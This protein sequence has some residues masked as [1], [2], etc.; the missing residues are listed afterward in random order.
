MDWRIIH[1]NVEEIADSE[2]IIHL[3]GCT[4]DKKSVYC[5]VYGFRPHCYLELPIEYKW[6]RTSCEILYQFICHKLKECPPESYKLEIR[7]TTLYALKR[8]YMRINFYTKSSYMHLNNLT[9]YP[10][11]IDGLNDF[12]KHSFKLHEQNINL[13]I[14]FCVDRQIYPSGWINVSK[15]TKLDHGY[16]DYNIAVDTSRVKPSTKYTN[17][18]QID[19]LICVFDIELHS[20]NRKSSSP[21]ASIPGNV[22]TMISLIF[23][24]LSQKI[25]E[26]DAHTVSLYHCKAKMGIVY[27]CQGDEKRLLRQFVKVLRNGKPDIITGYNINGFDWNAILTR[28]KIHKML[29]DIE[30]WTML[31][32]K[33]NMGKLPEG[34][35]IKDIAWGS[36]A[37][38]KQEKKYVSLNGVLNYDL[39]TEIS[40]NHKL[41]TYNLAYV[42]NHFLKDDT[43]DDMPFQQM[44]MIYDMV[45]SVMKPHIDGIELDYNTC[46]K[47]IKSCVSKE[48]LMN[49]PDGE[50]GFLVNHP[51]DF[52]NDLD[53]NTNGTYKDAIKLCM[54]YW[55]KMVDYCIQDTLLIPKLMVK[56]NSLISLWENS[57]ICKVPASFIYDRGQQV[58]VTA[59]LVDKFYKKGHVFDYRK[60]EVLPKGDDESESE[61]KKKYQGANLLQMTTGLHRRVV[62]LD[63]TSLYPSIMKQFNMCYT[64]FRTNDDPRV[65][66]ED[67]Y[68]AEWEE[69]RGCVH[70]TVGSKNKNV[71]CGK[72]RYRFLKPTSDPETHGT[73]PE[74]IDELLEYRNRVK[75]EMKVPEK[76]YK[77]LVVLEN[78]TP[79]Q[80]TIMNSNKSLASI[81]D[82]RQLAIKVMNNS[83][84]GYTGIDQKK[85]I[86]PCEAIA[87]SV[88]HFSRRYLKEARDLVLQKWPNSEVIYGDSVSRDTPLLLMKDGLIEIR[89]IESLCTEWKEYRGF[90]MGIPGLSDKQQ[91]STDYKV[92]TDKGWAEIKRV[93]RHHTNKQ[94]YRVN[95]RYGCVDVTEDHSLLD[96]ECRQIKPCELIIGSTELL[97]SYNDYTNDRTNYYN[98]SK[99][100][101]ASLYNGHHV[102]HR[103]GV[104]DLVHD[105]K[106]PNTV[107]SIVELGNCKDYV[108]DL[109][110]SIGRF[111]A[112]VGELIVK[113]T[114]SL[115]V[116]LKNATIE[117]TFAFAREAS[118]YLAEMLPKYIQMKFENVYDPCFLITAKKY[119]YCIVNEKGEIIKEDSKGS[120]KAR[121][122]NCDVAREIYT[123]VNNCIKSIKPVHETIDALN[124]AILDMFRLKYSVKKYVIYT[125]LTKD[126]KEY[127]NIASHIRFAE[128]LQESGNDIK[129]NTRLEF[130]FVKNSDKNAKSGE[131][132]EDFRNFLNNGL[133]LDYA[134]YI[135]HKIEK[136]ITK[137]LNIAYPAIEKPFAKPLEGFKTAMDCYLKPKWVVEIKKLPMQ[138]K[139]LYIIR[140]SRNR[141]LREAA[142]IFYSEWMLETL[143]KKH[144]LP[145]RYHY[146]KRPTSNKTVVLQNDKVLSNIAKYHA[147][148]GQVV[149]QINNLKRNVLR[150]YVARKKK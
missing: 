138:Q 97:H 90:K 115:F 116:K 78:R 71:L 144:G 18:D 119:E 100:Y 30:N 55:K 13:E 14:K 131:R 69:H 32:K 125:C 16:C 12:P 68:I 58:K 2:T 108:Y 101:A 111:H 81:L 70:D 15:I 127:K 4:I 104:Y 27:D 80:E 82:S 98:L 76:I 149:E 95:S 31:P 150:K 110:T 107:L 9:K 87:A 20:I 134:Y 36:S 51:K 23:G 120:M 143:F 37:R 50:G 1:W 132:M 11:K 96:M 43:K 128:R 7:K 57:N 48:E 5:K 133:K 33:F 75:G 85:G 114:D 109:E 122:D 84:Y 22:I 40:F 67:C 72:H 91:G 59:S 130:V 28:M 62:I 136:P 21:N 145:Y 49:M 89:T 147:W 66:D 103:D 56:L 64:T 112:G 25:T 38:G 10:W 123:V 47:L 77:E 129:A 19:P 65:K 54:K 73:L 35:M 135:D 146:R 117:E 17:N 24:R 3:S 142:K 8:Q 140:N 44:F 121:R 74:I 39:F 29:D 26:W 137:I 124:D 141:R 61:E 139:A 88:T 63:F 53:A 102:F 94:M 6:S 45:T 79:E 60:K 34:D 83:I 106:M 118:A 41:P 113:N 46:V 93:I 148:W 126:I 92:W 99:L 105:E 86:Q 52:V 42:S